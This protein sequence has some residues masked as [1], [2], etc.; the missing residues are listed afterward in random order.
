MS[1]GGEAAGEAVGEAAGGARAV[2]RRVGGVVVERPRDESPHGVPLALRSAQHVFVSRGRF[3]QTWSKRIVLVEWV[4]DGAAAMALAD[5]KRVTF[6]PGQV[7]VYLPSIPMRF[8]AL[9]RLNEMCWFTVDGPLA[10]AFAMELDLRPG[11]HPF[12]R[13]PVEQV[14][15]MMEALKDHTVQGRRRASLLAIRM[16]YQVA[17]AIRAPEVPT[18]VSQVQQ[19]IQQEF[20]DPNL[21]A[22]SIAERLH[23]HRVSLSR[24]FHRA[25]G[26][27]LIDYL[28]Q[29]RLQEARALLQHT[30][31]K[32]AD[33]ARKCGFRDGAYFARWLRRHTGTI[34]KHLRQMPL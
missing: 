9:G 32:I 6:E 31:D 24:L 21:S 20:A 4:I 15:E 30:P 33:V 3:E 23:Y 12:G 11:V 29:V 13:A 27:T 28:T 25:T 17:D 18:V 34:P 26:I 10:D 16:L 7:A 1:D 19:I 14:R 22:A 2:A 5:G 8:W